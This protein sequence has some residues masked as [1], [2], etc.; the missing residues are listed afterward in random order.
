MKTKVKVLIKKLRMLLMIFS[1]ILVLVNCSERI[2]IELDTT[3]TRLVVE[4][5]IT[6]DTIAHWVRL[7]KSSDYYG[8]KPPPAVSNAIVTIDDGFET[9][10][11]IESDDLAGY[12]QTYDDYF[13]IP[14]R[15]YELQIEL[16]EA[17]NENKL[18]TATCEMKPVSPIDSIRLEYREKYEVWE[19][20][21]FA[22]EPPT[23]DFYTFHIIKNGKMIT[24]TITEI[25]ISDDR[26][27]NGH[28][29]NGA[30]VYYLREEKSDEAV[31]P[32]DTITLMM[33]GIT[34]EYY[35]FV[36]ELMDETFEFRNPM[37]SGPPA[38][39]STNISN[40]AV[41]FFSVYSTTYS[42]TIFSGP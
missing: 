36:I 34:K 38:N 12:Y 25:G 24:D 27:F 11:L 13:G 40:D 15:T 31:N 9:I 41:G 16:K 7:T 20:Q 33:S 21:I 14:G 37:F 4:G 29:T 5:N 19:V 6:S 17:I 2:D 28:Y 3:Y 39:I 26:F 30:P 18:Y 35:N 8:D 32:G 1:L 42:T 23:V 10:T 22:L